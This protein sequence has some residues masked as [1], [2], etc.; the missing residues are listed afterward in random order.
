MML[1]MLHSKMGLKVRR[2]LQQQNVVYPKSCCNSATT[3][4]DN[5]M[6]NFDY[7]HTCQIA[8]QYAFLLKKTFQKN[9]VGS[10]EACLKHLTTIYDMFS[11]AAAVHCAVYRHSF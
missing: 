10:F 9:V 8:F 3:W 7:Y 6:A 11:T 1:A 5:T 4:P 2:D